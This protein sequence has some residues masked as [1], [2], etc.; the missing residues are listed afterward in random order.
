MQ[1]A[2][3]REQECQRAGSTCHSAFSASAH[4]SIAGRH[5]GWRPPDSSRPHNVGMAR[6]KRP[7]DGMLTVWICWMSLEE[8]RP[9]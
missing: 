4:I 3:R 2:A 6:A 1:H 5:C 9:H 7:E 8:P